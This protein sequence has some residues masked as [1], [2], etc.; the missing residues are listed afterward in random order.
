MGINS[1]SIVYLSLGSN[2]GDRLQHLLYAQKE[3]IT[4]VGEITS[5]SPIYEN[6][7]N[8]FNAE[9]DFLNMCLKITTDLSPLKLLKEIKRI[10]KK[11]GRSTS[12]HKGYTS[13]CIDIDII[14]YGN[15]VFHNEKLT[16]PHPSFRKR[17][18]VLKPL[19]DIALNETDHE[20][21]LTIGQL[22]DNCGDQSTMSINKQ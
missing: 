20:T 12:A 18:F 8:G 13:R 14:L 10:E 4:G 22:F 2:L 9:Q 17:M 11:L 19:A 5:L 6:P 21:M 16:I 7:P 15:I 3:L 1:K